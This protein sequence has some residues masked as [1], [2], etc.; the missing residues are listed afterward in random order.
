LRHDDG[1]GFANITDHLTGERVLQEWHQTWVAA[2][3]CRNRWHV[4]RQISGSV[5]GFNARQLSRLA[6]LQTLD[7]RMTMATTQH[8]KMH[9]A[10]TLHVIHITPRPRQEAMIFLP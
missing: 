1:E 7:P 9:H 3:A 10:H 6:D 5:Y 8:G 2:E 4:E